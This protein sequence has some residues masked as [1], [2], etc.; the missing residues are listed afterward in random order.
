MSRHGSSLVFRTDV[1][2]ESAP[3][4]VDTLQHSMEKGKTCCITI[5]NG[6]YRYLFNMKECLYVSYSNS[7]DS[8]E[9]T[10]YKPTITICFK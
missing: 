7:S 8:L 3:G 10:D 6:P 4:L 2:A 1:D 9:S 5:N